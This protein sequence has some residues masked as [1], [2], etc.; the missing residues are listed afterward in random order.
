[1]AFSVPPFYGK[2]CLQVSLLSHRAAVAASQLLGGFPAIRCVCQSLLVQ[3]GTCRLW[4][5]ALLPKQMHYDLS[6]ML[7][8]RDLA[9]S[10]G[11]STL[12]PVSN[13]QYQMPADR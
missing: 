1:M 11:H 5:H 8:A 12:R 3:E 6:Q 13:L 10:N 7:S 2:T 4:C 9:E